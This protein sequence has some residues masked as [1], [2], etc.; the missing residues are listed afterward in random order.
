MKD[1]TDNDDIL[2]QD[3]RAVLMEES[4]KEIENIRFR[5][6]LSKFYVSE[7]DNHKIYEI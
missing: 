6:L 5:T 7:Y 3:I 1:E 2:M 4:I